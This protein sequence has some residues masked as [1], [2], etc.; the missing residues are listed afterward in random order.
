MW[1]W[2]AKSPICNICLDHYID[3]IMTAAASQITSFT[4]VYSVIYSG[5]DQRKYQSSASLAFVR[6]IHRDR[7]IPHTKGQLR[8]KCFHLMTSSWHTYMCG[9]RS[10]RGVRFGQLVP[11][12]IVFNGRCIQKYTGVLNSR[13]YRNNKKETLGKIHQKLIIEQAYYI[14]SIGTNKRT[15]GF[16]SIAWIIIRF[17]L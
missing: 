3:V 13:I 5:A 11:L 17:G 14:V 12:N 6:G 9:S 10:T 4:I 8:G 16:F 7:W 1:C 15:P 2:K